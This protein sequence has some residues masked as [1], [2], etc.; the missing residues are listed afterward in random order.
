MRRL[1]HD[2]GSWS[3][4]GGLRRV[5]V[6]VFAVVVGTL[7]WA[8]LASG[9]QP[10]ATYEST[11]AADGPVA[12]YRFDDAAGSSTLADSAGSYTAT[13][14][15]IVLGGEGP[16]GGSKSGSFGT[17]AFAR[18]GCVP[19]LPGHPPSGSPRRC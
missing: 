4:R 7:A 10:Y 1:R 19:T 17:S 11:V 14:S 5:V 15:G 6:A 8:G 2:I 12:Q 16:F 18:S 13:N 9:T 3:R